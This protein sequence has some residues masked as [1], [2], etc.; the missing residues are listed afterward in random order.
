MKSTEF[1]KFY[2]RY[3]TGEFICTHRHIDL[4]NVDVVKAAKELCSFEVSYTDLDFKFEKVDKMGDDFIEFMEYI[5][6]LEKTDKYKALIHLAF[7]FQEEDKGYK[8]LRERDGDYVYEEQGMNL[9]DTT[10][11]VRETLDDIERTKNFFTDF[12]KVIG[13]ALKEQQEKEEM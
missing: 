9:I 2:E 10:I 3:L 8:K 1:N 11:S 6:E 12:G 5:E 4:I 7:Y 13:K